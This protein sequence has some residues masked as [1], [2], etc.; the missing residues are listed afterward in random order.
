V[1]RR[2]RLILALIGLLLVLA[3]LAVLV[4]ALTPGTVETLRATLDPVLF[5][6]PQVTP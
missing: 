3:A 1:S 6:P 2:N 4:L 5:T